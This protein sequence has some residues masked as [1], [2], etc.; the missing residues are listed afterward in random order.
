[1]ESKNVLLAGNSG[2]APNLV[3]PHISSSTAQIWEITCLPK[4]FL[5]SPMKLGVYTHILYILHSTAGV[6]C[7]FN[8]GNKYVSINTL[9]LKV[10]L[11]L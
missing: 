5:A 11:T 9:P 8:N 3:K 7:L 10:K 2:G 1:M 4:V 6:R